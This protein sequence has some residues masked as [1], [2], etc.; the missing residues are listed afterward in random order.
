M[1]QNFRI[2]SFKDFSKIY[3]KSDISFSAASD[4]KVSVEYSIYIGNV[5][6]FKIM[7]LFLLPFLGN[8]TKDKN[9]YLNFSQNAMY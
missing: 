6:S 7:I 1:E 9:L 3:G 8:C 5:F 2:I 4:L